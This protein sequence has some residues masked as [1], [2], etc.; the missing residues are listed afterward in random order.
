[1]TD[2]RKKKGIFAM[3]HAGRFAAAWAVAGL[4]QFLAPS[5]EAQ[6]LKRCIGCGHSMGYNAPPA[7]YGSYAGRQCDECPPAYGAAATSLGF[8]CC[9]FPAQWRH[10][11][12]ANYPNEP[13]AQ[14]WAGGSLKP[15]APVPPPMRTIFKGPPYYGTPA[16]SPTY[17]APSPAIEVVP[18]GDAPTPADEAAAAEPAENTA[19][20]MTVVPRRL[21]AVPA[22]EARPLAGRDEPADASEGVE[23]A[24]LPTVRPVVRVAQRPSAAY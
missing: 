6:Q 17:P 23:P 12:W 15:V 16:L 4:I 2:D 24:E 5:A 20:P 10:N 11:V 3:S 21:S 18:T 19:P 13:L 8:G 14:R 22:A 1:M 9:E 7:A